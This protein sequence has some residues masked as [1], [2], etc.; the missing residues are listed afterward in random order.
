MVVIAALIG[1]AFIFLGLAVASAAF[2]FIGGCNE[3]KFRQ[4]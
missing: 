1:V 4:F 2:N 3:S